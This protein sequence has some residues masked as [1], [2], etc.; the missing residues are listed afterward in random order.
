M[1]CAN[2]FEIKQITTNLVPQAVGQHPRNDLLWPAAVHL[3]G[4]QGEA[5]SGQAAAGLQPA[6]GD[7][8]GRGRGPAVQRPGH[9]LQQPDGGQ[10][11][12]P[13]A[14]RVESRETLDR[15]LMQWQWQV[16]YISFSKNPKQVGLECVRSNWKC[17]NYSYEISI[18]KIE[19]YVSELFR[20]CGWERKCC[21]SGNLYPYPPLFREL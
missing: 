21:L 19:I 10:Q 15:I 8:G 12:G 6:P 1:L 20:S 5:G 11:G 9:G 3:P 14:Q 7:L 17:T 2:S 13:R 4:G 16:F 18:I